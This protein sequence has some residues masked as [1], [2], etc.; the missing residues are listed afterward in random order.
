M[1][2]DTK[3]IT[4]GSMSLSGRMIVTIRDGRVISSGYLTG[5]GEWFDY[6]S[7]SRRGVVGNAAVVAAGVGGEV[8]SA[9]YARRFWQDY[10]GTIYF[11]FAR[12]Q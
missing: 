10:H 1:S 6:N 5:V 11:G 12:T 2:F 4:A 9:G 7:N 8:A 3:D